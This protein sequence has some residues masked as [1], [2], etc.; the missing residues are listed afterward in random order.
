MDAGVLCF[1]AWK[2]N[3]VIHQQNN[4]YHDECVHTLDYLS[5]LPNQTKRAETKNKMREE[6]E[7][8]EPI[9]NEY[10]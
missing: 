2:I 8:E 9:V 3:V 7:E 4:W 5:F 6:E 10:A 1:N